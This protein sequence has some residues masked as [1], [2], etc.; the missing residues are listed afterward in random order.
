MAFICYGCSQR[1]RPGKDVPLAP[2]SAVVVSK[3]YRT[4]HNR[5]TNTLNMTLQKTDCHYHLRHDRVLLQHPDF[6]KGQDCIKISKTD[7]ARFNA[8]HRQQLLRDFGTD[9]N[10]ICCS[11]TR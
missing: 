10:L 4:Y 9:V 11:Q 3:V 2:F 6:E 8:I 5:K 7:R 1:L